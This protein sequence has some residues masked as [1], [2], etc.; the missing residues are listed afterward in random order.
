MSVYTDE[1]D[2]AVNN[3]VLK[4]LEEGSVL[5]IE[6]ITSEQ[7]FTQPPAHY[8]EASLVKELEERGI[9]RPSTYSPTITTILAR[10]YVVKEDRNLYVTELGEAVNN[11]M[12]KSF[13][14]IVNVDF[15]INIEYM[16]DCISTGESQWRSVVSEFYPDLHQA[17]LVAQEELEKVQIKDE[18]T[19]VICEECGRNMVI[20][21]GRHGKFLAC[22][23]FPECKNTKTFLE[24]VGVKCPKCGAEVVVRRTKTGRR[25]YGCEKSPECDFISWQKPKTDTEAASENK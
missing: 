16:L 20:K 19:D 21:Y 23:G 14:S 11:I 18:E 8:T 12:K 25:F 13:P 9:G 22:P 24:K 5:A 3:P 10:R 6:N 7:H 1:E 17:V 15:T 4:K 2:T